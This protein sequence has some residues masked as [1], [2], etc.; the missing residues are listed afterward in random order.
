LDQRHGRAVL[1]N[2]DPTDDDDHV[3][4][5]HSDEWNR[6]QH[7]LQCYGDRLGLRDPC[8]FCG[9]QSVHVVDLQWLAELLD[10]LHLPRQR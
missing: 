2:D 4:Q 10:L 9:V 7:V 6:K 5:H 8:G 1:G 3:E